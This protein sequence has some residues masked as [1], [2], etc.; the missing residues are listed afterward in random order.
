MPFDRYSTVVESNNT[1]ILPPESASP[2]HAIA[3]CCLYLA[4]RNEERFRLLLDYS[5]FYCKLFL[6]TWLHVTTTPRTT[7][8][9]WRSRRGAL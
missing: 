9:H 4:N 6:F 5:G 8:A 7:I 2:K 1:L 3:N